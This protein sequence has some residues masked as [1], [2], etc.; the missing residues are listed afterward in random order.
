MPVNAKAESHKTCCVADALFSAVFPVSDVRSSVASIPPSTTN[1]VPVATV[2]APPQ[3]VV[4]KPPVATVV[5][6]MT[7]A[8][9]IHTLAML[10]EDL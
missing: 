5:T 4:A 10:I 6:T 8:K 2:A 9:T 3:T 7:G 1:V